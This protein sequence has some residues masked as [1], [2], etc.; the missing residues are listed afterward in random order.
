MRKK[1]IR[2]SQ[3]YISKSEKSDIFLLAAAKNRNKDYADILTALSEGYNPITGEK[4]GDTIS[5]HDEIKYAL[6][7]GAAAL[8]NMAD[9]MRIVPPPEIKPKNEGKPW[10]EQDEAI[11]LEAYINE[12]PIELL[13]I[14]FGRSENDIQLKLDELLRKVYEDY[15]KQTMHNFKI[16][17]KNRGSD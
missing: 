2:H 13:A 14:D 3:K 10:T 5:N 1:Q 15:K 16:I 4:L 6:V 8:R 11:L 7:S 9:Y 17:N 12:E